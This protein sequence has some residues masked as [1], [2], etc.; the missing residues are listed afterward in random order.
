MTIQGHE[1][2]FKVKVGSHAYGTNIETSDIDYK[3]VFIQDPKDVYLNGYIH[4]LQVSKD[5]V[6]YELSSYI[7]QCL[8]G[9][10]TK[11]ELLFTPKNCVEYTSHTFKDILNL[12]EIFLTKL[13]RHSFAHYALDQI[14]KAK[15]TNK[16][17]NWEKEKITR[18]SVEDVCTVFPIKNNL[19]YRLFKFIKGERFMSKAIYLNDF[20]DKNKFK[21]SN[22]G[23]IK[24][25]H[26]RDCYLLFHSSKHKYRGITSGEDANEVCLSVIPKNETPVGILFFHKDVYSS[27]CKKWNDY[28]KWLRDR[29][30]ARYVD[31]EGHDQK[32]DGKNILHCVRLIETALEIPTDKTINVKRKNADY[33][34]EIR[35]GKHDLQTLLTKCEK[36]IKSIGEIFIN[37][38]LPDKVSDDNKDKVI[39][40]VRDIKHKYFNEK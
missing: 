5:E 8:T 18:K 10:P 6:Y 24:I 21:K 7:D 34:I 40:L 17:M 1:I 19:L 25:E 3:G 14:H 13:L 4:E 30:T 9:N 15:G 23:L 36:D 28:E 31:I 35:R 32:I 26:F 11:L 29:N 38:E 27:N 2:L 12:K 39:N 37:S 33:L 22:C 16:K 20:L